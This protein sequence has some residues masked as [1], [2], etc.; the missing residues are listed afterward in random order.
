MK[1][2]PNKGISKIRI[3]ASNAVAIERD[4]GTRFNRGVNVRRGASFD[5][6]G[7]EAFMRHQSFRRCIR[8]V[9]LIWYDVEAAQEAVIGQDEDFVSS[10][11]ISRQSWDDNPSFFRNASRSS[12]SSSVIGPSSNA[13]SATAE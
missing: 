13:S 2:N 4:N 6:E 5:E 10:A 1:S 3:V 9:R 12:R 7:P 8:R 11:S